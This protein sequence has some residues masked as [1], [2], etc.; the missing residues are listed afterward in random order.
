MYSRLEQI[1]SA[2]EEVI[3]A[4]YNSGAKSFGR[5]LYRNHQ[6]KQGEGPGGRAR[7]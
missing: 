5:Y 1:M 2:S 6:L 3:R 4:A 7:L